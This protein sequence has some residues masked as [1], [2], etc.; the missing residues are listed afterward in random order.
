MK[1]GRG[2]SAGE[3][4]DCEFLWRNNLAQNELAKGKEERLRSVRG[5][6]GRRREVKRNA[7]RAGG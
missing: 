1:Q 7:G 2:V 4:R 3:S 5:L 6:Q